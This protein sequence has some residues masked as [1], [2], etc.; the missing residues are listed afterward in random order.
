MGCGASQ[1][2]KTGLHVVPF[3]HP[4][5]GGNT[6]A[7]PADKYGQAPAPVSAANGNGKNVTAKAPATPA[8]AAAAP[9]PVP[10]APDY[11]P[12][13]ILPPT[14][15]M[16]QDTVTI[17]ATSIS[18]AMI[19]GSQPMTRKTKILCTMGRDVQPALIGRKWLTNIP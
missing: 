8:A 16:A 1:H 17:R 6:T 15:G 19:C 13:S 5:D 3:H 10:W 14:S 12:E 2:G 11:Q 4:M 7:N 9:T 18:N